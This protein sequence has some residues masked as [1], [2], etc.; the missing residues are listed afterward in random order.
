MEFGVV[1]LVNGLDSGR[2]QSAICSTTPSG[3][4]K[5][6][7]SPAVPVH[8]LNRRDGNDVRLIWALRRLFCRERPDVVHTHGWGTLLEGIIAARLARVPAFVHGEHG[9]MQLKPHQRWLQRQAW[10]AA[11]RVLSVSSRL[12]ERMTAEIG[13]PPARI[14]TIRNGVDL[15]RFEPSRRAAC[16]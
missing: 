12:A 16:A 8:D 3:A 2:V 6:L 13:V 11:D 7:V 14:T 1:K 15:S 9:T 5:R 10:M 4:L